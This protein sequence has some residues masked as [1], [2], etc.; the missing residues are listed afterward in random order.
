[1]SSNKKNETS[2]ASQYDL[3]EITILAN[4]IRILQDST[5][6]L[7]LPSTEFLGENGRKVL[8]PL[9]ED[10]VKRNFINEDQISLIET[11]ISEAT[12]RIPNAISNACNVIIGFCET[13]P[14]P[15]LAFAR[16][17]HSINLDA[18]DGSLTKF[19]FLIIDSP[20]NVSN[21]IQM[22]HVIRRLCADDDFHCAAWIAEDRHEFI[23]ALRN[24]QKKIVS[25]G[26][27]FSISPV[28]FRESPSDLD[29]NFSLS[30]TSTPHERS[31]QLEFDCKF[32]RCLIREMKGKWPWYLS[33]FKD[34]C[35]FKC[36]A[37][38]ILLLFA[39]LTPTITFGALMNTSTNGHIGVNEALLA[40]MIHGV[41][42]SLTA[43]QPIILLGTTGPFLIFTE[44]LYQVS[45]VLGQPFL[46]LYLWTGI[47]MSLITIAISLLNLCAIIH[48]CTKF[49]DEISCALISVIYFLDPWTHNFISLAM[50]DEPTVKMIM[51][52]VLLSGTF[53]ILAV[54]Q[55]IRTSAYLRSFLR[56]FLADFGY[57]IAILIM[58]G[59]SYIWPSANVDRLE[60]PNGLALTMPQPWLIPWNGKN[61]FYTINRDLRHPEYG[62]RNAAF[63]IIPFSL[64]PGFLGSVLVFLDTNL[65]S[66]LIN[67]SANKL[68][69]GHGFHLDYFII[70][71]LLFLSSI[72]GLPWFYAATVRSLT[73]LMSLSRIEKHIQNRRITERVIAVYEN[74]LT[75]L[76]IHILVG[77]SIFL[78]VVFNKIP[79]YT[80][81]GIFSFMG[82]SALATT[83]MF[84]RIKLLVTDPVLY[85]PSHYVRKI[86]I[87][88]IHIFTLIQII[89]V[90]I[91]YS[92][93]ESA[94]FFPN[95]HITPWI[96]ITFPILIILLVPIRN[97]ALPLIINREYLT[98]LDSGGY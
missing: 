43:A 15:V 68:K 55:Y 59:F 8:D 62:V 80:L 79:K 63:W 17:V 57:I 86:P 30:I 7:D 66:R 40:T 20:Q 48:Y 65:T 35:R 89:L 73:H 56:S 98:V 41:V 23:G 72:I 18:S 22:G 27:K 9:L 53:F 75:G 70:S 97:K 5:I 78:T 93:S 13:L 91:L 87:K 82:Y 64:I 74:R 46:Y 37:T 4:V 25:I 44:V 50:K 39:C 51:S 52:F 54:F 92:V 2:R 83:E 61:V 88:K 77:L 28:S 19:V 94:S 34:G 76:L 96:S 6:L 42:F 38:V 12:T 95:S 16:L 24:F 32:A 33:D 47:W 31:T 67:S 26:K 21:L 85:P 14:R 69:K 1:M 45:I 90:C 29:S 3:E 84:Q 11:S 60:V 49:T 36:F 71:I 81:L 10:L 58:T